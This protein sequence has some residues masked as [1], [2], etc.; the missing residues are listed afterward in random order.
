MPTPPPSRQPQQP[1]SDPTAALIALYV[2]AQVA[3]LTGATRT[4]QQLGV[5]LGMQRIRRLVQHVVRELAAETPAL[6]QSVVDREVARSRRD[7]G[8]QLDRLPG[9][10]G[11]TGAGAPPPPGQG[12]APAGGEDFFDLSM[13]HGD[14]AAQAIRDD[15]T[16]SL[17]DVRSRLTRLPDDIYKAIAP[18]GGIHQVLDNNVT[19]EQAQAAAWRVFTQSGVTGFTDRSGRDWALSSYVEMAVRTAANRAYNASHTAR[20]TAVGIHY[21]TIPEHVHPCP[22]CFPWQ[23]G[24][25]TDLDMPDPAVPVI[26]TV[27]E[28]VAAGWNHPNCRCTLVPFFPGISIPPEPKAWTGEDQLRYNATQTQRRL[29]VEIRK[30]KRAEATALTPE[31]RAQARADVRAAQARIRAFLAQHP[32]L[33]RQSR[34]EQPHL[35]QDVQNLTPWQPPPGPKPPYSDGSA[36]DWTAAG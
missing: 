30:A 18:H 15:L 17:D 14:R 31:A 27:A 25:L 34:R 4:L 22:A 19:L 35:R 28:A 2:A 16:S 11:R 7:V 1:P 8:K 32:S 21:F 9:W 6:V 12:L 3:L 33:G 20:M 5:F 36:P 13:D 24:V 26:G 29:E 23:H 10:E